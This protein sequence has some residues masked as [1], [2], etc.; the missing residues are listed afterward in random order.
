[1]S[2]ALLAGFAVDHLH[3]VKGRLVYWLR[4]G[5]A[6]GVAVILGGLIG[7]FLGLGDA[8]FLYSSIMITGLWCT[9]FGLLV[10][11]NPNT[12]TGKYRLIWE[13]LLLVIVVLDLYVSSLDL[14]PIINRSFFNDQSQVS[15]PNS[16]SVKSRGFFFSSDDYNL[17]YERFFTFGDFNPDGNWSD[18]LFSLSSN[19]NLLSGVSLVNNFDPL[20]PARYKNWIDEVNSA[21]P[22][23]ALSMLKYAG[24]KK[25][26]QAELYENRS[27]PYTLTQY[28]VSGSSIV[29][30][31]SCWQSADDPADAFFPSIVQMANGNNTADMVIIED[32]K[33]LISPD[34]R[35]NSFPEVVDYEVSDDN[36]SITITNSEPGW[37]M[38][39]DTCYPGWKAEVDGVS[40]NVYCADYI[41]KATYISQPGNHLVKFEYKPLSFIL[42]TII[43]IFSLVLCFFMAVRTTKKRKMVRIVYL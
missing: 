23:S 14:N 27:D 35:N 43:S 15:L 10:L 6:G 12:K 31:F 30:W 39:S 18:L 38:L 19:V 17:K 5:T 1:M 40:Q 21:P 11:F 16:E 4:L 34:C 24:V 42:G 41:Y 3:P 8:A 26:L 2:V 22:D 29:R 25:I 20:V 28:P 7:M 32:A 9:C 13:W 36:L 33:T 37:L